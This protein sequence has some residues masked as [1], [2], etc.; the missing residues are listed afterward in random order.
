MTYNTVRLGIATHAVHLIARAENGSVWVQQRAFDKDTDPLRW[1]TTTGGLVA[2]GE[3]IA[4]TLA[5]E[6]WEEAGLRVAE[7]QN[8]TAI[9]RFTVRRPVPGGYMVEHIDMFEAVDWVTWA[10]THGLIA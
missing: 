8:V 2:A 10:T 5:R 7:L 3:S 9:G 1:D 6:T 4:Q